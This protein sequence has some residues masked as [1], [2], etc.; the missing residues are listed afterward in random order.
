MDERSVR[1]RRAAASAHGVLRLCDL[2]R[3]GWTRD[4]VR[5]RVRR[6]DWHRLLVG[7]LLVDPGMSPPWGQLPFRTRVSAALAYHGPD[8]VMVG[9]TGGRLLGVG[10]L[11]RDDG[12]VHIR[13][14]PGQERHQQ[15]G[16]RV[17]T[18][19][20]GAAEC[21]VVDGVRTT[22]IGRTVTDLVLSADRHAAVAILDDVLHQRLL[23]PEQLPGLRDR[24]RGRRGV[25][26][27]ARWWDLAD[28]RAESPLETRVRLLATD[29]GYPP[30][31]LQLPVRDAYGRV[32]GF[33]DLAWWLSGGRALIAEADGK[34][35]HEA[36]QALFRDRRR[37]ND[38][39]ATG[40]VDIVRFT[41]EDT[42]TRGYVAGVLRRHL[43]QRDLERMGVRRGVS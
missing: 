28:G 3:L 20:L 25:E 41:W 23:T 14:S 1:T 9:P 32:L 29:A 36:P 15:P 18:L 35:P 12:I 42:L 2:L 19:K 4:E 17:H 8:A 22:T 26:R 30:D 6:G 13:R 38:F 33:G 27:S 21:T 7:V 39:L 40:R 5:H 34:G 31:E 11:P 10:A 43:G 16:V 37:A 24:A